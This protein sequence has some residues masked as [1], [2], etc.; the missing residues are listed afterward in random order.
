MSSGYL[1]LGP[2]TMESPS[3]FW[4]KRF[5]KIGIPTFFWIGFYLWWDWFRDPRCGETEIVKALLT[6]NV[7]NHLYFLVALCG[8]SLLIPLLRGSIKEA[9]GPALLGLGTALLGFMIF[10]YGACKYLGQWAQTSGTLPLWNL[11]YFLAGAGFQR[12]KSAQW[13]QLEPWILPALG[14]AWIGYLAGKTFE[15]IHFAPPIQYYYTNSYFCPQLV[16]L[17]LAIFAWF[18]RNAKAKTWGTYPVVWKLS[19]L[20]FGLYLVHY[21]I[22][23]SVQDWHAPW[24]RDGISGMIMDWA[25]T[26]ILSLGVVQI[27]GSLPLFRWLFG[28]GKREH[29]I[30][31]ETKFSRNA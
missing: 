16:L 4:Q 6:G 21:A 18:L 15:A 29:P 30:Q 22:L 2:K 23:Q 9:T 24:S 12:L 13:K 26:V 20:S 19:Q 11:G 1:L 5:F 14:I 3:R 7:S 31:P 27:L 17:S 8:L 25:I 10:D 28:L